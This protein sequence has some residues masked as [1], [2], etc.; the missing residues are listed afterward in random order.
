MNP[1]TINVGDEL[2][3]TDLRR[4][5]THPVTVVRVDYPTEGLC[6]VRRDDTG[7]QYRVHRGFL[8]VRR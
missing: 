2:M 3:M 7:D 4:G 8:T 6:V 5:E 1:E